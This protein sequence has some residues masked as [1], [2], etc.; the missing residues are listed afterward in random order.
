VRAAVVADSPPRAP[1]RS[2]HAKR[3]V[4]DYTVRHTVDQRSKK[5]HQSL[6]WPACS[7]RFN[8][9]ARFIVNANHRDHVSGYRILRSQARCWRH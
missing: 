1:P 7:W 4:P 3:F 5:A 8:H 6:N 9:I 2:R